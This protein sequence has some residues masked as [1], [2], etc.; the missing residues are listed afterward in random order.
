MKLKRVVVTGLGALTPVGNDVTQYWHA[1]LNGVSGA[2]AIT[3]FNPEKFKTQFGC[4]LK[5]FIASDY[6]NPKEIQRMD[7]CAQYA[8]VTAIQALSD[9]GLDLESMDKTRIGA[10][11]GTGVGGFSSIMAGANDFF[12]NG[13]TP[14]FSP[15]LI[16]RVLSDMVAGYISVKFGLKGPAYVTSS[17]CASSG[18]AIG[19][20]MR[21]IQSGNADVMFTG[22]TEACIVETAIGGFDAMH[23]LSVRN[24]N[25]QKASR[26]FDAE[27][28]GFVM[29]EGSATLILE[30]MEHAIARGATIYAELGGVGMSADAY[31]ATAPDPNGGGAVLSMRQALRSADVEPD[32]VD[33]INMHAT[34]TPLGDISEC[35]AIQNVFG[36]HAR[37][38][39]F[40]STKSMT[41]HLLGASGAIE[42]IAVILSIRDSI[43]HPTI[44]L[45]RLDPKLPQDWNYAANTTVS[46]EVNVGITNSFGFGGHNVSVLFKKFKP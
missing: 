40:N 8:M 15:Y 16:I 30:E 13:N 42:S 6:L 12:E 32:E 37:K 36:D 34:S 18:N 29:G 19:D 2:A 21:L 23:A 25:P 24:D 7:P 5:G 28:D 17:A 44:N 11:Y 10:I 41:G 26:P 33:Y 3:R 35:V 27:R 4:E 22:G 45:E 1:L 38:M 31:H 43:M 9:S 46:R 20:A 14:R 39:T